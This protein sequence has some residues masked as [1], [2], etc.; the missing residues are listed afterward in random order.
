MK[1]TGEEKKS[2]RENGN[3]VSAQ[4]RL[5]MKRKRNNQPM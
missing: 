5:L 2:K 4:W 1:E 3:H